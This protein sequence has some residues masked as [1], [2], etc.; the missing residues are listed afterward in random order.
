[1]MDLNLERSE[2]SSEIAATVPFPILSREG[3]RAYRRSLFRPSLIHQCACSPMPGTLILRNAAEHSTFINDFWTHPATLQLV[4]DAAGIPLSI[5]MRTEIGHTN[6]QT[7][8]STM[9]EMIA[10]LNVEPDGTKITL[11]EEEMAYDPLNSKSII[12]WHYDS[13]PYVCVIMLSETESMLG[14]ETYIKGGDGIPAKVES[15]ALGCGVILQGGEVQHLAARGL[16]VKERISTIT[17]YCARAPGVYDSSYIS[18]IRPYSDINVLYKQWTA[19]RLEKMKVE[20]EALQ[21]RISHHDLPLDVAQI[22]KFA[23]DQARYL[24]RTARQLIPYEEHEAM[25]SKFG[26]ESMFKAPALWKRAEQ[27]PSFAEHVESIHEGNWMSESPFWYDLAESR[28]NVRMG[29]MLQA[30]TGR[31]KWEKDRDFCMG[32][33]LLRQG[34]PEFFLLWL[35]ACGLYSLVL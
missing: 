11:T 13:Y 14:G 30:Q 26:K 17:S 10:E 21:H 35:E 20:I 15:P 8:G 29:K 12:P 19:Y 33:E 34:L 25:L 5:V 27:L 24:Q 4:S 22:H 18:N 23:K 6:I 1:M 2:T 3:V 9:D 32:D 28:V 31:Y 16:G 7:S